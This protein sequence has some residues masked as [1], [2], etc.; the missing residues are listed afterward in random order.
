MLNNDQDLNNF[1]LTKLKLLKMQNRKLKDSLIIGRLKKKAGNITLHQRSITIEREKISKLRN[2][3][4]RSN[5]GKILELK[6][7]TGYFV[8]GT[9]LI[10]ANQVDLNATRRIKN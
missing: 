10:L 9:A 4:I 2:Q 8:N 3:T 1:E 7:K 5:F 6:Q